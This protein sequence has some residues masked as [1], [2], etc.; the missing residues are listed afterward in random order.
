MITK[1]I[2]QRFMPESLRICFI[3]SLVHVC[4]CFFTIKIVKAQVREKVYTN[5]EEALKEPSKVHRLNL[6]NQK[7]H[8]YFKYLSKFKNLEYLNLRNTDLDVVPEEILTLKHLK[9]LDIG[10]NNFSLLPKNF[11]S[12]K[13]LQ[14]LYLDEDKNLNLF[15]GFEILSQLKHLRILHLENDGIKE[16][17]ENIG[18]LNQ[19]EKLYLSENDLRTIPMEIKGM[20]N[21]NYLDVHHNPIL[22]PLNIIKTYKGGLKINF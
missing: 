4:L 18:K 11:S 21:L 8:D 6:A 22:P 2:A 5:I 19:I 12:L 10:H 13:H 14:E 7:N 15:E 1:K 9:T 3:L 17:P 16:L 20:K